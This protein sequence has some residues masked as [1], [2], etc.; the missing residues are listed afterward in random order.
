MARIRLTQ[1]KSK[2]GSTQRQKRTLEALGIKKMNNPVEHDDTPVIMGM[3][4][5]VRHLVRLE[6]LTEEE[7][8]NSVIS[9]KKVT[10]EQKVE[11]PT[12]EPVSE[13][14]TTEIQEVTEE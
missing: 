2:I 1:F 6:I 7:Q 14:Q 9:E 13:M 3:F 4:S 11:T 5:K 8:R 10:V 12:V